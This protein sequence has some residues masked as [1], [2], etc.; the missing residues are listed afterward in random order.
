MFDGIIASAGVALIDQLHSP[1]SVT[2][3]GEGGREAVDDEEGSSED[4]GGKVDDDDGGKV[5]DDG[6]KVEEDDGGN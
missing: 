4:D 5:E 2:V 1:H 3:D 6:G